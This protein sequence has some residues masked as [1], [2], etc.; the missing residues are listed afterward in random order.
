[1][2]GPELPGGAEDAGPR[3]LCTPEHEEGADD[4]HGHRDAVP[5]QIVGPDRDVI[6]DLVQPEDLVLHDP[7]VELETAAPSSREAAH[8]RLGMKV[9]RRAALA[10]RKRPATA[11]VKPADRAV[12]LWLLRRVRNDHDESPVA[13]VLRP[14]ALPGRAGVKLPVRRG[15]L[16]A[17]PGSAQC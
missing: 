17:C 8:H 10:S 1:M 6:P 4:E 15:R 11:A 5:R 3:D 7:V 2:P 14:L 9:P 12:A 16:R 13:S